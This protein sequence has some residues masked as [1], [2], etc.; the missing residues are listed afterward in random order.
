MKSIRPI[1]VIVSFVLLVGMACS[2]ASGGTPSSGDTGGSATAVSKPVATTAPAATTVTQ[3][4]KGAITAIAD[5]EKA[6]IQIESDG[7]FM[8]PQ[9]G[10][11][12][13]GGERGSGFIIDPSGI[14]VTNNHVVTGGALVKVWV[15]GV[16]HSAQILGVSEC[17]DLAVIKIDGGPFPYLKWYED[18][19]ITGLEVYPAG[20]PLGEPQFSL[21]KGIISKEKA[22]GQTSWASLDYV[23]G[24]D[25]TINPGNSGGPLLTSDARVVGINYSSIASANQYFAIDA[26]TAK[27]VVAILSTGKDID[28]IGIS[29]SAVQAKDGS[30][31]GIWVSSV[32]SG[33]PAD[34]AGVK[35]GDI[36]TK[37][38][39]LVLATDGT[40]KDYCSI[41]RSHKPG[42]TLAI[43]ILRSP[44]SELLDGELN[45]RELA[46]TGKAT[47]G[48]STGGTSGGSTGGT[49][50]G[51]TGG[52]D[53]TSTPNAFFTENFTGD[54]SLSPPPSPR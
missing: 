26:K 16:Q 12:V 15:E 6:V 7:T 48:G 13:N 47:A 25:A 49:T 42:D 18:P 9:A 33:S 53:A 4:N 52:A 24:Q 51:N 21:T 1:I 30:F 39:N 36:L 10:L 50:G 32:K 54:L 41:L 31:T 34:K 43:S 8:D 44:T 38:E 27:P 22:N 17:S 35:P 20:F 46:V 29:G 2:L 23:L 45:G 37:L 5:A 14:A 3:N 28:T 11:V 19:V 40:M